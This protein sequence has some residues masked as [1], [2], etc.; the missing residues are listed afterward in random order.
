M[1][2]HLAQLLT[3]GGLQ[4]AIDEC[5]VSA[6][7]SSNEGALWGLMLYSGYLKVIGDNGD[8]ENR[9]Y[10]IE[11]PNLEVK[12]AYKK[13][14]REWFL[15]IGESAYHQ[16]FNSLQTGNLAAFKQLLENYLDQT[17]SYHDLGKK[18]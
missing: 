18:H 12:Q 11:I 9:E 17:V 4:V 6:D 1:K 3:Q 15:S 13:M 5:T 10:Q 16:L 8:P 14:V 7:L 2:D